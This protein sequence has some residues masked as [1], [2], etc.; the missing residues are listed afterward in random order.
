MAVAARDPARDSRADVR[1]RRSR[2][3]MVLLLRRRFE[4]VGREARADRGDQPATGRQSERARWRRHAR[5]CLSMVRATAERTGRG[6]RGSR[7]STSSSWSPKR[8]DSRCEMAIA[9]LLDSVID[10]LVAIC[11]A[12]HV[13][14]GRSALFNRAACARSVPGPS[15]GGAHPERGRAA[16]LGGADLRGRQARE[17][18]PASRSYRGPAAPG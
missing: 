14:T 4:P 13:F 17:S 10:E 16:D 11:G 2:H 15:V 18:P 8:P 6:A 7:C 3:S 9:A 12:D 5:V 1:R